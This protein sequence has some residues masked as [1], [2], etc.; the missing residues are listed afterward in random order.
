MKKKLAT[1]FAGCVLAT[2][3]IAGL[4]ACGQNS[5]DIKGIQGTWQIE[6]TDPAVTTV[7]TDTEWKLVGS[8]YTYTLDTGSKK[9]SF[10]RADNTDM[11]GEATYEFNDDYTKL[12]ITQTNDSGEN[13][14]QVFDKLSDDTTA[15]PTVDGVADDDDSAS[16]TE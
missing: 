13:Q 6:S 16:D 11:K 4:T 3:C 1:L 10:E 15:E 8:T 2:G 7:F 14:S 12:T 5:A 9:M